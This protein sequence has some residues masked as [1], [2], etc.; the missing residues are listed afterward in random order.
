M[1]N[2]FNVNSLLYKINYI[3]FIVIKYIIFN[4]KVFMFLPFYFNYKVKFEI[5]L[6]QN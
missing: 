6:F 3:K 2:L 4:K 5:N 1:K